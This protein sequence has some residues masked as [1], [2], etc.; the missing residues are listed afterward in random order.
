MYQT[1]EKI[2]N[3]GGSIDSL[4]IPGVS[5]TNSITK[6]LA[7]VLAAV[8][9]I[10]ILAAFATGLPETIMTF[11]RNLND[12]RKNEEWGPL[13]KYLGMVFGVI[14]LAFV[15]IALY[16]KYVVDVANGL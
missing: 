16:N 15:V 3:N 11:F 6:N 2:E 9:F 7:L 5:S 12:A 4:G 1:I 14:I 10:I 13:L 8:G